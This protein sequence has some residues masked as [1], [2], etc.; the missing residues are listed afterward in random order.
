V[1]SAEISG[2]RTEIPDLAADAVLLSEG[3]LTFARAA[4]DERTSAT[5]RA[6]ALNTGDSLS[7]AV[8]WTTAWHM[9]TTAELPAA[10]F[11]ELLIRRLRL[12]PPLPV[13]GLEMLATRA[14]TAADVWA[15]A[16]RRAALRE[17]L[18]SAFDMTKRRSA[19][20]AVKHALTT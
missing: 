11:V 10:D 4:L 17:L 1:V 18:A 13:A 14:V 5:L 20:P 2:P 16:T 8:C 3:D 9:V 19:D 15:P 7:E 6:V 12:D